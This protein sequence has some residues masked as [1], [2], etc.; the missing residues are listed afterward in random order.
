MVVGGLGAEA[1]RQGQQQGPDE[2]WAAERGW[3]MLVDSLLFRLDTAR[4]GSDTQL[5]VVNSLTSCVLYTS[6]LEGFAGWLAD[7]E[8]PAGLTVD[9]DLRWRLLHALVAHGAA[10]PE[11]I[12]EELAADPTSTGA[13]QAERARSLVPTA[14]AKETAWRRAVHDDTLPNAV[15]ESIISGFAH[16]AQRGLLAPYVERYFAEV[17]DVWER[18]TSEHAQAVVIG[19]FPSWAVDK[20][21]VD[22]ADGWLADESHP[23]SLRRLVTEGR[24][25]IVRAL[26]AREFD[27][28]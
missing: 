3:P 28:S 15:T 14:E 5:A 27:R 4:A 7:V 18:R 22:A 21:T 23:P 13:R 1:G 26:G 17:A 10:P 2:Q 11:R 24:A 19:L 6:V 25:G 20:G 9:T 8:V 12:E 16:P